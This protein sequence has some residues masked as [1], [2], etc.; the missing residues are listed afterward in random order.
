MKKHLIS[1]STPNIT[2][3]EKT[4]VMAVLD[5]GMLVQGKQTAEFEDHFARMFGVKHAIAMSTGTSALYLALLANGIGPGD[6][7]I[8]TPFTF[9]ATANAILYCGARP[10][11]VDI[12]AETYNINPELIEAAITSRTK[13][14]MP[15]HLYGYL[16]DMD[17]IQSIASNFGLQIIE[18]ACQ[19]VMA[20]YQ[21]KFAG[22][23][24]T[25]VFSFYATKNMMT[26]EGGMITTDDEIVAEKCRLL[27][28]HGMKQRY[29]HDVLGFNYRMTDI[30]AAIGLVQLKRLAEFTEKRRANAAYFNERLKYVI[31]P[32]V[33]NGYG[34]VWHQYTVRVQ[35]GHNRD[36]I[37]ERLFN[38]G[39]QAVTYYPIPVHHQLSLKM[40]YNGIVMP[41]TERMAKE[42]FSLPV[43][44]LLT[45]GELET[46]VHCVNEITQFDPN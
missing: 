41:V 19:A 43:H 26:G 36:V 27:R 9:I 3:A 35:N 30:Q 8:T 18:D 34:H 32:K 31:K 46:I 22:S 5:S 29:H 25:G 13:A 42:V 4:A 45:S 15:V 33:K 12:D 1:I 16:C 28:N 40:N 38:A 6:E 23:F 10:V 37:V 44:P 24:G 21:N 7:V 17:R 2:D 14:I 20:T 11:F 39:V